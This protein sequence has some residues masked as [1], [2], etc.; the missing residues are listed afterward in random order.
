MIDHPPSEHPHRHRLTTQFSIAE[1][2]DGNL[3]VI[4]NICGEQW[5]AGKSIGCKAA[6]TSDAYVMRTA[7]R[8]WESQAR[9]H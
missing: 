3:S 5:D 6:Y 1:D 7:E 4:C 9:H 2:D 8:R